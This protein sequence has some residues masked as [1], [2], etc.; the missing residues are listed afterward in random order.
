MNK[1]I[2]VFAASL[3]NA[4]AMA[5]GTLVNAFVAQCEHVLECGLKKMQSDPNANQQMIDM[6]Q[7]QM[8]GKCEAQAD[9]ISQ[10]E[11]SPYADKM[12]ACYEAMVELSCEELEVGTKPPSCENI[13]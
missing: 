4:S 1:Q 13:N 7:A 6:I 9:R 5:E 11:Q 8:A 12:T 2:L 3:L 10:A